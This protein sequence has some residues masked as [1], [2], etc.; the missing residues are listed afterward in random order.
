MVELMR[1]PSRPKGEVSTL[2]DGDGIDRIIDGWRASGRAMIVVVGHVGNNEAVAAAIAGRGLP[3]NVVADDS[4]VSRDLRDPPSAAR[5]VGCPRHPVAQPAR[6]LRGPAQQRDHGASRGL[7]LPERRHPGEAVWRL[8]DAAGRSRDARRQDRR[9]DR[10]DG[11][12]SH[13]WAAASASML[14]R[15]S[16]FRRRARP[17]SSG[18]PSGS[19]TRSSGRSPPRRSSGTASSPCGRP[20]PQRRL[21]LEARAA[22]M[23]AGDRPRP[24]GTATGR[25]RRRWRR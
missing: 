19:R 23:L 9:H 13:A 11:R 3:A 10:A 18:P 14:T 1:L 8:D 22:A 21:E 24:Q 2:V 15:C 5:V 7:G 6:A 17:T 16:P 4:V 12:P 20:T 25:P